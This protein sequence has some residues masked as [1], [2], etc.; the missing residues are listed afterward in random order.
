[1]KSASYFLIMILLIGLGSLF[2][3][4]RPDGK[5]WLSFEQIEE[6]TSRKANAMSYEGKQLLQ[7][8]AQKVQSVADSLS[9]N[10]GKIYKWQD[11]QGVWHYSD[12]PNARG[13][14]E[15]VILD[16]NKITVMSAEDT[17]VLGGLS[18]PKNEPMKSP[19]GLTTIS[20]ASVKQLV[21]D[22]NN[23]QKLMDERQKKLDEALEKNN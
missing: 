3:L 11:E 2:V 12:R 5:P 20:P 16:P 8:A 21:D 10:S 4:K 18:T 19:L 1:M 9:D 15:E 23:V 6:T 13:G 17:S 22:A 14:S 7:K